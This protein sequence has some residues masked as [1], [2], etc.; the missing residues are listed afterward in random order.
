[1]VSA[2]A[3]LFGELGL[4]SASGARSTSPLEM[5]L[6][7]RARA[8]RQISVALGASRG[9][10]AS[11]GV[12]DA[13]AFLLVTYS[14][15]AREILPVGPPPP[16]IDRGDDDGDGVLNHADRCPAEAEDLDG[17]QDADGCPDADN[18]GDGVPDSADA[19][20]TE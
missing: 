13:R 16:P 17:F 15:E 3:E 12:P 14:P 8:T 11:I 18:D 2:V 5:A 4:A 19:C 7:A 20:P 1:K 6:G 10:T 9:I